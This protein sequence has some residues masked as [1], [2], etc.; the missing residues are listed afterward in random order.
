MSEKLVWPDRL[1]NL[2]TL[3]VVAI[4]V[5]APIPMQGTEYDSSQWWTGNLW[6]SISRPSVPLFVMLSGFLLF[7]R[8]YPIIPFLSKRF[9]R[10]AIP[11]LFWMVIYSFYNYFGT[12]EP[13]DLVGALKGAV[14]GPVHYHLWFLYLIVGLY[15]SYPILAPFVRQATDQ[16]MFFFF[17]VCFYGTWGLKTS[18]DFFHIKPMLYLELFTNNAI[19]FIGGYY[20]AHKPCLDEISATDHPRFRP[21]RITQKQMVWAAIGLILL[22]FAGTSIGSWYHSKA[23]GFFFPYYYDYLTPTATIGAAG[24]FL[25]AK[26]AFN[27]GSLGTWEVDLSAASFGIYLMHP[28]VIDW[29]SQAG[30]WQDKYHPALCIPVLVGLV[31]ISAFMAISIIRVLP[32]GD[33][34]T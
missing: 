6:C 32:G 15:M 11:A 30:Y 17:L 7:S 9:V 20:L 33:K 25:F 24:W 3:L 8:T 1:R 10:V 2:A 4:H 28:M 26:Y 16:E 29:W 21:W 18:M 14:I 12:H 22:S 13:A 27:R 23:Q 19:Y 31:M 5:S 34:V